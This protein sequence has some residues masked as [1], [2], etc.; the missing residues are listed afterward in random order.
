M[1]MFLF[2]FCFIFIGGGR[3]GNN[4]KAREGLRKGGKTI[5]IILKKKQR[6]LSPPFFLWAKSA[7]GFY[8]N[9]ESISSNE[10]YLFLFAK[11]V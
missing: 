2:F 11:F 3:E 7:A 9:L 6:Y 10:F 8:D 4:E 1:S 5:R